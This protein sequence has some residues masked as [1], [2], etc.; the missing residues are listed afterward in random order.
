MLALAVHPALSILNLG[1]MY[2]LLPY[3]PAIL[4]LSYLFYAALY[5]YLAQ[6]GEQKLAHPENTQLKITRKQPPI[7]VPEGEL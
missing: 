3:H 7:P 5:A 1:L 2:F 4:L 6:E